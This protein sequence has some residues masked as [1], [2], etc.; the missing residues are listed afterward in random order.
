MKTFFGAMLLALATTS[1][2]AQDITG[3]WRYIDDKT[4]EPKALVKIEKAK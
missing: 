4:G 2:F 1:T 3:T